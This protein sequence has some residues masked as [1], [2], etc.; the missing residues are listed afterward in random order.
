MRECNNSLFQLKIYK[1]KM[2]EEINLL[3]YTYPEGVK[4]EI[5][6]RLL[7]GLIQILSEVDKKETTVGFINNYPQ[8]SK[9][10]FREDFLESVDVDWTGYSSAESYFNQKPQDIK[11]ML[12]VMALDLLLM[13]KQGH[14]ENIESG[15][16]KKLGS[17]EPE[18][19]KED[20]KLS[21][22]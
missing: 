18:N 9:E 11:T 15:V 8:S 4:V 12:G 20:V 10:V 17:F 22:K 13:L 2:K 14:L 16:A 6:G 21:K 19:S 5:P 7:E 1:I 3:E